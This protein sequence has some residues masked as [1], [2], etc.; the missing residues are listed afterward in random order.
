MLIG[1][2]VRILEKYKI[3]SNLKQEGRVGIFL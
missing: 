1:W 2:I 3:G